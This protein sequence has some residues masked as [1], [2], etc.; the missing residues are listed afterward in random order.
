MP[1]AVTGRWMS[2]Q[3]PSSSRMP[4]PK[5][6]WKW[7]ALGS[8]GTGVEPPLREQR[9][10]VGLK[11]VPEALPR[12]L[13]AAE[14]EGHPVGGLDDGIRLSPAVIHPR[15]PVQL[16]AGS[17]GNMFRALKIEV[18]GF[19]RIAEPVRLSPRR[20]PLLFF[21]RGRRIEGIRHH[22]AISTGGSAI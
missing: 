17:R 1:P 16:L 12:V 14:I 20:L 5:R 18:R 21:R 19:L 13:R 6:L 7:R 4:V 10:G 15:S 8:D 9:V 3:S 11:A 2:S 22:A